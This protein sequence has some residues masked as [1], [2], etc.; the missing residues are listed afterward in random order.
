M[1]PFMVCLIVTT[2]T[3]HPIE[4]IKDYLNYV[5]V[6]TALLVTCENTN[7]MLETVTELHNV[8]SYVNVWN[9]NNQSDGSNTVNLTQF[10]VRLKGSHLVVMDLDC[11]QSNS[12]LKQ[13]SQEILFHFER[14]WL[15][16][17][18]SSN[19]SYVMLEPQNINLDADVTLVIPINNGL[20]LFERKLHRP[21][22][23]L[24]F[25]Q[26]VPNK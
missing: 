6:K 10:F 3:S 9:W 18:R 8:D 23:L 20:I 17:S 2:V 21:I 12:F 26:R 7:K 19:Q 14:S 4:L 24:N 1:I 15:L 11:E 22:I 25:L 16:F 13:S 5:N